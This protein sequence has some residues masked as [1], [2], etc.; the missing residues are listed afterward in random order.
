[1]KITDKNKLA[2]Y[3]SWCTWAKKMASQF[4]QNNTRII[5]NMCYSYQNLVIQHCVRSLQSSDT[6][7]PGDNSIA[8][9]CRIL[10][11]LPA[12]NVEKLRSLLHQPKLT[13]TAVAVLFFSVSLAFT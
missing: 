1:M 6:W 11:P 9:S 3:D 8:V 13:S 4:C 5:K 7:F 10:T 12:E 2:F